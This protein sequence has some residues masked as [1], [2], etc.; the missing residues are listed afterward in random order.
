MALGK[1]NGRQK[2]IL[3]LLFTVPMVLMSNWLHINKV[4]V[5]V[6]HINQG[7]VGIISMLML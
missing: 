6:S 3:Y 5:K 2:D 4:Q 7:V 1:Y